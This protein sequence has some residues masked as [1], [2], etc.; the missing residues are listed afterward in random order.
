MSTYD[1]SQAVDQFKGWSE[2]YDECIIQKLLFVPSHN[3]MLKQI[4]DE[5]PKRV[6]DIGGG[7]GVF[8]L[9]CAEAH[10]DAEIWALD[11]SMDMLTKGSHRLGACVERLRFVRGDSEHLPFDDN[12]FDV[13]TC[14]NSFH[15]YPNQET[16]VREMYRVLRPG[17]RLMIVDGYRD[18]WWGPFIYDVCVVSREGVV[19]H[20]PAKEFDELFRKCGFSD[21]EQKKSK[22]RLAPFILTLGRAD[23]P[24]IAAEADKAIDGVKVA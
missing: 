12:T 8:A 3:S 5:P 16:A 14:A 20:L 17:G 10:T 24:A 19:R 18:G 2:G 7:T 22:F 15:H 4:D 23:K 1:K 13:I 9:R 6:L 21:I 11:L